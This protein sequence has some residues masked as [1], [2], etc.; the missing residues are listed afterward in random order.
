MDLTLGRHE[1]L[2]RA[3]TMRSLR[4]EGASID[5]IARLVGYH[6]TSVD[7][8]IRWHER[9]YPVMPERDPVLPTDPLRLWR[10]FKPP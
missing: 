10:S 9:L 1:A 5:V 2:C 8:M 6:P 4:D 7:R 3:Y